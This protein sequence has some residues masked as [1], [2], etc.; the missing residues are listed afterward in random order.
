MES[1]KD[2]TLGVV[3]AFAGFTVPMN[4]TGDC[5]AYVAPRMNIYKGCAFAMEWVNGQWTDMGAT[6]DAF[7]YYATFGVSVAI[8]EEG[9]RLAIGS[10]YGGWENGRSL[11]DE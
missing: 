8:D 1:Q 9:K 4:G 7:G 6:F 5:I 2:P 10:S 3:G 11:S